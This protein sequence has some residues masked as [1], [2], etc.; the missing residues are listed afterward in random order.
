MTDS[1]PLHPRRA[2]TTLTT[3]LVLGSTALAQDADGWAGYLGGT[4]IEHV[5]DVTTDS[6]GNVYVTGWT[7]QPFT[8][9]PAT[10]AGD[11]DVFV[12]RYGPDGTRAWVR[13]L[14]GSSLDRA[15]ELAVDDAG[16]IWILGDTFSTNFPAPG[17]LQQYQGNGDA[18][19]L[20]MDGAT[21]AI[22]WGTL[23]GGGRQE[24]GS[25]LALT[26]DGVVIC[27]D[28]RSGDLATVDGVQPGFGESGPNANLFT[29]GFVVRY[30]LSGTPA[31]DF[32]TYLGGLGNDAATAVRVAADGDLVVTGTT[33]STD[34]PTADAHQ[35]TYAGMTS[36]DG[37]GTSFDCFLTRIT[38]GEGL[39]FSTYL[40]GPGFDDGAS[41]AVDRFG[42]LLIAGRGG[43]GF[44]TT[45]SAFQR[46]K[47]GNFDAFVA[48]FLDD[49]DLAWSTFFGGPE[50]DEAFDLIVLENDDVA[51]VG[52]TRSLE[53]PETGGPVQNANAGSFDAFAAVVSPDGTTLR[54]TTFFGG[55]FEDEARAVVE[56]DGDLILAGDSPVDPQATRASV[57]LPTYGTTRD[58]PLGGAGEGFLTRIDFAGLAPVSGLVRSDEGGA[59]RLTWDA[60]SP[61]TDSIEVQRRLLGGT[62]SIVTTLG[63]SATTYLDTAVEV[64]NRGV[65]TLGD[66]EVVGYRIVSRGELDGR[67]D[68]P[69]AVGDS[70]DGGGDG[71]G[72]GGDDDPLAAP[73]D[74]VARFD[75]FGQVVVSW[76]DRSS[77]ES[78]FEIFRSI[79]GGA[80][81]LL[82]QRAAGR[83]TFTDGDP[84]IGAE[85]VYSVRAVGQGDAA[86]AA[87]ESPLILSDPLTELIIDARR[88]SARDRQRADRDV[89]FV[90]GR[91][92][93]PDGTRRVGFDPDEH[94]LVLTLGPVEDPM[95]VVIPAGDVGWRT[96]RRVA[97]WRAGRSDE[98]LDIGLT[99]RI[100]LRRGRFS[101][102]MKRFDF[103]G[104]LANPFTVGLGL[105]QAEGTDVM[106]WKQRRSGR[107]FFGR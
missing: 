35:A 41:L 15:R 12:A 94:D 87:V 8:G 63:G 30:D 46:T 25:S 51:V 90:K 43:S 66:V 36:A 14:G 56:L 32:M 17:S 47:A 23:F 16:D 55:S 20:R 26:E 29:D 39:V 34:F 103:P 1:R 61:A 50:H 82:G 54:R 19:V 68:A 69:F 73:G 4:G 58:A 37:R 104:A 62:Y 60:P 28:T 86:S 22:E 74:V 106:I 48:C 72:D 3:L 44:P 107:R 49:G 21:G 85:L 52:K 91:L 101:V 76:T 2:L 97:V 42:N 45:G 40:G 93:L 75:G 53:L 79:D 95:T 78:G 27:G 89:L 99:V 59:L 31:I 18:F 67:A 96:R 33:A 10:L 83:T 7:S 9:A 38:P 13:Y 24:S 65:V 71:S 11:D 92:S 5:A 84:P 98:L 105:G 57:D 77:A 6:D 70:A 80:P 88:G 64:G 102:R 81:V 100:D